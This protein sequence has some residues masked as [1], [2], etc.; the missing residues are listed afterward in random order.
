M[1]PTNTRGPKRN[2]DHEL[3]EGES[4]NDEKDNGDKGL[5]L[6]EKQLESVSL[7]VKSVVSAAVAQVLPL[8]NLNMTQN[9]SGGASAS[10]SA[11]AG[12]VNN[13]GRSPNPPSEREE[14]EVPD[15]QMDDY[16]RALVALLGDTQVT[17]PD[18]SEKVGRLLERCLG[19]PLDDK[20]IKAKQDA[21]PRPGNLENLKVP[22]T[23]SM[24]FS[25]ASTDHQN[26]DRGIQ[27]TQSYLVA[28]MTAVGR[29]A[30]KLLGLRSWA[31]ALD[32]E[33]RDKLPEQISSLTGM[34]VDLMYSLILFVKA[35]ADLTSTRRKMFRN[36]LVYP[37]KALNEEQNPPTPD[38][39]GGDDVH[40]AIRKAKAN[41]LLAEDLTRKGKWPKKSF[42]RNSPNYRPYD[43]K[44]EG[45]HRTP[46]SQN[47]GKQQRRKGDSYK[48]GERKD[49][50]RRD[51]R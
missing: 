17:G 13:W 23:N 4:S 30:E 1:A 47:P 10:T 6:S 27:L 40:G 33:E 48:Q 18:M 46:N 32:S 35:M 45:D 50:W 44:K 7:L 25:K 28:G 12:D 8:A 5:G 42:N 16:E 38:W 29:Q 43:R 11:Q 41:A 21:F 14:G 3:S 22:R 34:Y 20:V 49:F 19:A 2:P 31:A 39:L 37:Y 9:A 26:L 36:D 24:I 51:S 15:E